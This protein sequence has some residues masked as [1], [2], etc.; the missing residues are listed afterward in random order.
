[1]TPLVTIVTPTYNK[2]RLF[3]ECAATVLAQSFKDWVWWI[4]INDMRWPIA[5]SNIDY[6]DEIFD[7]PRVLTLWYPTDF[8]LRE[9]THVPARIVNWL[10]P[11]I[12]TP[13]IYFL[14]DDDLIDPDGLGRLVAELHLLSAPCTAV[15]GRCDVQSEQPDGSF[16]TV[17]W[18]HPGNEFGVDVPY[19]KDRDTLSITEYDIGLGTG[20]QP[21][22]LIDGGQVLHTKALW[23]RATADGWQLTD[24]PA[25]EHASHNDGTL[26]NRLAEFA[27]FHYVPQRIVTHR[28]TYQSRWHKPTPL[29]EGL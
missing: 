5:Y 1:M 14:A 19:W 17:G 26:L 8:H 24:S 15:Y 20:I 22:C 2:P 12:M 29:P 25:E 10:Y 28:R 3:A 23:D 18:L 11:K 13:Y 16:R 27:R 21:D 9:E 7:D 4:V 6:W